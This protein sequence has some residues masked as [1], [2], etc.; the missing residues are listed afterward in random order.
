[1]L[2]VLTV[3][4]AATAARHA[5]L[6]T[7][8]PLAAPAPDL[9]AYRDHLALLAAWLAPLQAALARHADGPQ[10]ALPMRDH[11][12]RLHADLADAALAGLPP[13]PPL[14]ALPWPAQ[15]DAAWRWGVAYV[16][17]GSQLGGAVLYKRLAERLAPH[18]LDYLRGDGPP[19]PRWQAFLAALRAEVT[20]PAQIEQAC[21]GARQAFDRLLAL[22]NSWSAPPAGRP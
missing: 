3:L 10:G 17:E 5:E 2:D 6:D 7:R 21:A 8:T 15:D 1:M 9:R 16:I 20:T 13:P 11:L 18:P 4:R 22:L 14:A 12:A 19:G